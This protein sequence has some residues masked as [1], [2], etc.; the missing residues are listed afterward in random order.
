MK[1]FLFTPPNLLI[2]VLAFL[3]V[4]FLVGLA[5]W[6]TKKSADKKVTRKTW[7]L[8]LSVFLLFIATLSALAIL[9]FYDAKLVAP[10]FLTIFLPV[11]VFIIILS[12]KSMDGSMA[13]LKTIS[14]AW[15]VGVQ[16]FRV[17]V[18]LILVQLN[19]DGLVPVELTY[20]GQNFDLII[21]ALALPVAWLVNRRSQTAVLIGTAWNIAGLLSLLNILSIAVRSVPGPFFDF[22]KNYLPLY[23]PGILIPAVFVVLA[24]LFHVVSLK[25]LFFLRKQVPAGMAIS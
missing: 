14:P 19:K 10:R 23:F 15:L 7:T 17:A 8:F 24:I 22:A 1:S 12:R 18:E 25:Q 2:L 6:S 9:G 5:Y 20:H 16:V 11:V 13:F 21:G 3:L 4:G